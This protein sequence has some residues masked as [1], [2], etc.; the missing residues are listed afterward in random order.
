M[1]FTKNVDYFR[2]ADALNKFQLSACE[3]HILQ[4]I[5]KHENRI[6]DDVNIFYKRIEKQ[7]LDKDDEFWLKIKYRRK[8]MTLNAIAMEINNSEES[9]APSDESEKPLVID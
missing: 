1:K 4:N 3:F 6:K 7:I 5:D 9:E 8:S 2:R